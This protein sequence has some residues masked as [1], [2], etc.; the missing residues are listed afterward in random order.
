MSLLRT[1]QVPLTIDEGEHSLST[2][3]ACVRSIRSLVADTI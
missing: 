2:F 3:E 1:V